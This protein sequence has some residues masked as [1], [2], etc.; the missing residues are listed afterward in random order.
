VTIII[1]ANRLVSIRRLKFLVELIVVRIVVLLIKRPT[2]FDLRAP[3][4]Y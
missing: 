2:L 3:G 1:T 4:G